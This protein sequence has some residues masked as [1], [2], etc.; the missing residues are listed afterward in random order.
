MS[1]HSGYIIGSTDTLLRNVIQY[2]GIF[3]LKVSILFFFARMCFNLAMGF[4]N[5]IPYLAPYRT[6]KISTKRWAEPFMQYVCVRRGQQ[7][8]HEELWF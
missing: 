7:N 6:R 3:V 5:Q 2:V 8:S 1:N 4:S